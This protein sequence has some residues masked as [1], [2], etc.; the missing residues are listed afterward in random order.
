M[1]SGQSGHH[2]AHVMWVVPIAEVGS[3]TTRPPL[4]VE[5]TALET[6]QRQTLVVV[7]IVGVTSNITLWLQPYIQ[8]SISRKFNI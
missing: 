6:L 2:G 4:R 8:Y 3:V 5:M 7:G 1:E